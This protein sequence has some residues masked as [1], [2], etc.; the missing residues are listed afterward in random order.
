MSTQLALRLSAVVLALSLLALASD[1]AVFLLH[2]AVAPRTKQVLDV[3]AFVW[4][5]ALVFFGTYLR[6]SQAAAQDQG[7][8]R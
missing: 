1:L 8:S 6:K 2:I 7:A 3:L 5:L 4:P